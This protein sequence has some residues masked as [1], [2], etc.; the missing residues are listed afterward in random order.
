V[1]ETLGGMR[2]RVWN[3]KMFE[4][5]KLARIAGDMAFS[6]CLRCM[7][8]IWTVYVKR[9][10]CARLG[11]VVKWL[12]G[13]LVKRGAKKKKNPLKCRGSESSGLSQG[14]RLLPAVGSQIYAGIGGIEFS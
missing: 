5:I 9:K 12:N 4:K 10:S 2:D 11:E 13:S 1:K 14:R 6:F 3:L 7:L 8:G